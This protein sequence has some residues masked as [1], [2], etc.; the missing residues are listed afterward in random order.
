VK[1]GSSKGSYDISATTQGE[2][3]GNRWGGKKVNLNNDGGKKKN[4]RHLGRFS[5]EKNKQP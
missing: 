3:P 4:R 2:K 1:W 5:I